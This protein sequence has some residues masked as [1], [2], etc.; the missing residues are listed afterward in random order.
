M[1][2]FLR[3]TPCGQISGT[4]CRW[5]GVAA[6]KGIRYATAGRWEYPKEVTSWDG[7]YEA[8]NYGNCSYQPRAFY[9]EALNP[10]KV[11]Y[12][13]EFRKGETYT[14]SDDC[15]FLNIWTPE[16]AKDGDDLPVLFYIHGGGF[17]GGC[18]HEKHFDGPVWPTKGVIGVTINY[19]LG[20]MGFFVHPDLKKEAGNTGNYALF[21]QLTAL[22]WVR[23]N[24]RA[25]GGNPDNIT[26]MG[27]SAGG[28]SVQQMCLT[29]LTDGLFARAVMSSG[30]GTT[31]M[32]QLAPKKPEELY[33][34]WKKVMDKAGCTTLEEFKAVDAGKLFEAW[35]E[36]K[37]EM[38][39]MGGCSP[40][41]D[42]QY[43]VGSGG[44]IVAAGKQKDVPYIL[45]SNSQDVMPPVFYKMGRDYVRT[46]ADQGKHQGYMYFFD[47]QLPGDGNGAWH[48]ADLWYWFGT[49][50]NSWR[51]MQKKD[52]DLSDEMTDYLTAF[53]KT[54]DPNSCGRSVKWLTLKKGQNKVM[55][56]G[57]QDTHMGGVNMMKLVKTMLTNKAV[58]E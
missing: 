43:V 30:G 31:N 23:N 57:E 42:G 1:Y 8:V 39:G 28:M 55:R 13:N 37:K 18:G 4:T 53:C 49:L 17:T 6:Y 58:G 21:D 40:V 46:L 34:S 36:V 12:Y 52:Y 44:E 5:P 20:P 48:S 50:E 15:L 33:D 25:F 9:D 22:K 3:N 38:P 11:F 24:I 41:L 35:S 7:V 16:T 45:G 51:P 29:P 19:R 54:G 26:I 47:R 10:G 2:E 32:S 56:F 27:Q 14:Y